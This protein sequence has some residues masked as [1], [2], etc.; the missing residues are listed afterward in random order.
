MSYE[1]GSRVFA[2]RNAD[3]TTVYAYGY[4][5]YVGDHIPPGTVITDRHRQILERDIREADANPPDVHRHYA[6][7]VAAGRL[8]EEEAAARIEQALQRRAAEQARPMEERVEAALR[9]VFGNPKIV[10]DNG[11]GVVWGRECW[12][13][14]ADHPRWERIL[15]GKRVVIVPAPHPA[16]EAD[17]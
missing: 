5:T 14:P 3:E 17:R 7:L 15:A 9:F 2:I 11:A 12:W 13:G 16:E 1:V 4:G 8:T 6:E 10:L